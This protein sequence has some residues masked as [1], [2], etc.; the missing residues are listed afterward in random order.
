M[1]RECRE[2]FPRY[3]FQ[4][5][6]LVS[7]PGMHQGTCVTHA[8]WC[9]SGSLTRDGEE[10][11]SRHSRRMRNPQFNISGKR[12]MAW[13]SKK[14]H[15]MMDGW[16]MSQIYFDI[17]GRKYNM[18]SNV[19]WSIT[20][21]KEVDHVTRSLWKHWSH[22]LPLTPYAIM[23]A[24]GCLVPLPILPTWMNFSQHGYVVRRPV[25]CGMEII[26]HSNLQRLHC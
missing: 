17:K 3:R 11:R 1:R 18:V 15:P 12:P 25:K 21:H 23:K 24:I 6:S 20:R 19:T 4:R 13:N 14:L 16:V 10:K 2:R 7:D 22:P 9:M 5:K 26:I 8:P